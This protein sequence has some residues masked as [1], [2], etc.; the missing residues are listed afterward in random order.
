MTIRTSPP[1]SLW[2]CLSITGSLLALLCT[3]VAAHAEECKATT[4]DYPTAA[5]A[6]Y[7]LGCMAANGNSFESLHQCSCSIDYIRERMS[8]EDYEKIQ[9]IMQVQQNRGQ[10]GLFYR[11]SNWAKERVDALLGIQAESTLRCF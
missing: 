1:H 4:H 9:T 10:R 2:R 7:V 8:F 11:D 5:I 3:S 6:D